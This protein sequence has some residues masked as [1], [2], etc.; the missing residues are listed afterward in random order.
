[1]KEF[2]LLYSSYFHLNKGKKYISECLEKIKFSFQVKFN[3]TIPKISAIIPVF[4]CEKT[5][6]ASLASIQNQK[7]KEIEII[8]VNDYSLDS[9][10]EII[11]HIQ[12]EDPRIVIINNNKNMGTLYSR[13][14]GA[15][16]AN[17]K[18]L[19]T[20]D[21]DDMFLDETIFLRLYNKAKKYDYDIIGFKAIDGYRYN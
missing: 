13:N 14:I 19:L 18:Y 12:K 4:N 21:N 3:N 10:K 6:K 15:F 20:L 2:F 11:E 8:L 1:M 17:G 5:I 9:S 7:L 16:F